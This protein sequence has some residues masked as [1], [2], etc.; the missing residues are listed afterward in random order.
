MRGKTEKIGAKEY[1]EMETGMS[2][3][4][5]TEYYRI[6][7]EVTP[8]SKRIVLLTDL[9]G[10]R[11]GRENEKLLSQID[12]AQPDLVCICGDM[13]TYKKRKKSSLS[14]K[15]TKRTLSF[16]RVL[17][18][19]YPV[20]YSPG[21]HEIRLPDYGEYKE[22]IKKT[23]IHYLENE[24]AYP[25]GEY[26][27]A[28]LDLPEYWYHKCWEKRQMKNS[29]LEALLGE[30]EQGRFTVLLAHNPEYFPQYA[31]W[32]ADMVCSG[33]VHG[34]MVRIPFLGGVISPS[35][36]LF[37]RFDAGLY[38]EENKSMVL[39]RGLGLHHIKIRIFNPPEISVID[40]LG[41]N[42]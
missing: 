8:A 36:R 22:E 2:F 31:K 5:K 32:G 11:H 10:N 28:G 40:I 7:T 20:Y 38:R 34:G 41:K 3:F 14:E 12:A 13:I 21:N 33:H 39:S 19:Q 24:W 23:G 27:I 26:A 42:R 17:A 15:D 25:D 29:D 1:T 16:L 6:V 18:K 37:P 4:L 9:H 35:L 30:P